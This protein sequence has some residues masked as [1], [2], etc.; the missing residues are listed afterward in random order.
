MKAIL[1]AGSSIKN[2]P[3]I[4]SLEQELKDDFETKIQYYKHWEAG[5]TETNLNFETEEL[6]KR[7]HEGDIII[8]KSVGI[9]ITYNTIKTKCIEPKALVFI[10]IPVTLAEEIHFPLQEFIIETNIPLLIIQNEHDPLG[11]AE[12]VKKIIKE[13]KNT[14]IIINK[15]NNTHYYGELENI[16]KE[17][18]RFLKNEV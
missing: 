12:A 4:E 2:K 15:E 6:S 16:R 9:L 14:T 1:L 5:E 17:I 10:V 7:I 8:A 11:S 18:M 13:R 3:W